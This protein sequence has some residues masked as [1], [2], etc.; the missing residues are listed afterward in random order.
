MAARWAG[1]WRRR[2]GSREGEPLAWALLGIGLNLSDIPPGLPHAACLEEVD[3]EIRDR[4][5]MAERLVAEVLVQAAMVDTDPARML[6][7]W[8]KRSATLGREVRIGEVQ[9]TAVDVDPD[10]ALRVRTDAGREHRVVAGDVAM[11]HSLRDA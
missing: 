4:R 3:E 5:Q 6:A 2:S 1:S 9:G 7:A 10:G 8:R 11:V